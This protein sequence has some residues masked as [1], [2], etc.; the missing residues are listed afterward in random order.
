MTPAQLAALEAAAGLTLTDEEKASVEPLLG[1]DNRNDVAIAAVISARRPAIVGE[2]SVS[3]FASWAAASNLRAAIEDH[4]AD[5]NSQLRS[6]AL[7]LRDRLQ[8]S[9]DGS[10]SMQKPANQQMLQAWVQAG[11]ITAAQRDELLAL[12]SRA[13]TVDL[14]ALSFALNVAEGRMNLR[15]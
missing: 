15:G 5:R 11:A 1:P 13:N 10:I 7:A 9:M 3:T 14:D 12:A 4:A 6:I 2:L 8:G